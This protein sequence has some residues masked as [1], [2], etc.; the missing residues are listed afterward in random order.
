M[1]QFN[2]SKGFGILGTILF[3]GIVLLLLFLM[4]FRTPLP[5]PGEEG[6]EVDLGLY[7]QGQ[8]MVQPTKP[9]V[10]QKA[11]PQPQPNNTKEDFV[12][13]DTEDAPALEKKKENKPKEDPKLVDKPQP[14]VNKRA[15]FQGS[16]TPQDGGSEGITGQ[17]GDQGNPNGLANIKKYDGQGGSGNGVGY[18]LGGR[19]SVH[20]QKPNEDFTEEG[21]IKVDIW[22]NRNGDVIRAEIASK[23]TDIVNSVMREKAR[24]AALHSKFV[25]DA[26]APD[27]QRGTIT[28]TFIINQ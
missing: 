8:G 4:G 15:L 18:S 20:L 17:L 25:D 14:K 24:Q 3:H 7:N 26:N 5:L 10:P 27:E 9:A 13:Q 21:H 1:S 23:G 16:D 28:Y 19:G 6:V 22:V 11:T 2:K 12:T